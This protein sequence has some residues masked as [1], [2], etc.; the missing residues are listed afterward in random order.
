MHIEYNTT[1]NLIPDVY[2][3]LKI[4]EIHAIKVAL[5]TKVLINS[6]I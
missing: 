2:S 5:D 3:F 6:S 1:I 4:K